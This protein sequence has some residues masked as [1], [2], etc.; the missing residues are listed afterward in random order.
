RFSRDWSS[1]VCSSDLIFSHM[2]AKPLA[3]SLGEARSSPIDAG[4]HRFRSEQLWIAAHW[5]EWPLQA[6]DPIGAHD[7]PRPTVVVEPSGG[8]IGRAACRDGGQMCV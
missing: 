2:P 6:I 7:D 8:Q 3:L 4:H 5:P 1:D